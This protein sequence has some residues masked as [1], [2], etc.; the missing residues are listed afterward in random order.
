MIDKNG[1]KLTLPQEFEWADQHAEQQ[2]CSSC[3]KNRH[4]YRLRIAIGLTTA[5]DVFY[6]DVE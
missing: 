1:K 3:H 2:A 4:D 6:F 5:F